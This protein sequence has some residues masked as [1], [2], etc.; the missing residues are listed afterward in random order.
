GRAGLRGAPAPRTEGR[1]TLLLS[2]PAG[3][4]RFVGEQLLAAARRLGHDAFLF[5]HPA[6]RD[7][8]LE[9]PEAARTVGADRV[10]LVEVDREDPVTIDVLR[11]L[12]AHVAVWLAPAPDAAPSWWRA[13][14]R[15]I[16]G[17]A[18]RLFVTDPSVA[19]GACDRHG[20]PGEVLARGFDAR[21][22]SPEGAGE[23]TPPEE[24]P[25]L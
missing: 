19:P 4:P 8:T 18:D 17:A 11:E 23:G 25:A 13:R 12:G 24:R 20:R 7:P 3:G 15:W 16:A 14:R 10:L 1:L 2:A 5:D 21:T 22:L 9:L 6:S